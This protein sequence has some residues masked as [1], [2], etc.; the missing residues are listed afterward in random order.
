MVPC[1]CAHYLVKV[2]SGLCFEKYPPAAHGAHSSVDWSAFAVPA[3]QASQSIAPAPSCCWPAGQASQMYVL[4][5]PSVK[6]CNDSHGTPKN[7]EFTEIFD[8]STPWVSLFLS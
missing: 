8:F 2:H 7:S 5:S 6:A 3:G 1:D 4:P